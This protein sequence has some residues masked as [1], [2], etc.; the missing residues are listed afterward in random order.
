MDEI[1]YQ[2]PE[3][4]FNADNLEELDNHM[5][6]KSHIYFTKWSATHKKL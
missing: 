6:G 3:C 2:C 4:N 1:V 5:D